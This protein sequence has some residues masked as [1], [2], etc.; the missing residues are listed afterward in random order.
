MKKLFS[1]FAVL[2][3][4]GCASLPDGQ[5]T[6]FLPKSSAVVTVTQTVSCK[7]VSSPTVVTS[8]AVKEMVTADHTRFGTLDIGDIDRFYASGDMDISYTEDGRLQG[9]N[10]KSSGSGEKVVSAVLSLT[11]L[12]KTVLKSENLVDPA[13]EEPEATPVT[14]AC[15]LI[16]DIA[17]KD[18]SKNQKPLT[19]IRVATINF[20]SANPYV[21]DISDF[22]I[23]DIPAPVYTKL[24][25]VIGELSIVDE[26]VTVPTNDGLPFRNAQTKAKLKLVEPSVYQSSVFMQ[27]DLAEDRIKLQSVMVPQWGREYDLPIETPPLFGENNIVLEL[28]SSGKIKK[29]KYGAVNGAEAFGNAAQTLSD[30][31]NKTDVEKAKELKDKS[32]LIVQQQRF[33]KCLDNPTDC[34]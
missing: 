24:L 32:D 34:K 31:L 10:S 23:K 6:Y 11:A 33:V 30:S 18:K 28:Y 27:S 16:N 4:S 21:T 1:I 15:G 29:L 17:G 12:G 7:D 20:D 19:L 13:A 8:A 3:M 14:K 26:S 9:I 22:F 25:P 2:S 5:L